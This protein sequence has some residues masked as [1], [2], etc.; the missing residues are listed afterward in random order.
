MNAQEPTGKKKPYHSEN[1]RLKMVEVSRCGGKHRLTFDEYHQIPERWTADAIFARHLELGGTFPIAT[2]PRSVTGVWGTSV[3]RLW[4]NIANDAACV[5]LAVQFI[6]EH[7][8]VSYS[9]FTRTKLARNLRHAT[10]TS[11]QKQR[12]SAQF[13]KLLET[14]NK[15]EEFA[16]Y[17]KLWPKVLV[18]KHAARVR[19]L[20]SG[21]DVVPAFR[22]RLLALLMSNAVLNTP[23]IMPTNTEVIE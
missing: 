14:G 17:L 12:L 10:I 4:Y 7:A 1:T 6:E 21:S 22:D 9:G 23:R 18:A 2:A 5:E 20:A 13:L 11:P 3:R 19:E 15:C 8:I 16:T